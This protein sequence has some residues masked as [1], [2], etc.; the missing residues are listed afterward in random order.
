MKKEY[1]ISI[2]IFAGLVICF[3]GYDNYQKSQKLEIKNSEVSTNVKEISPIK[4]VEPQKEIE[5]KKY[6]TKTKS[7][8]FKSEKYVKDSIERF[9]TFYRDNWSDYI[10]ATKNQYQFREVGGIYDLSILFVNHTEYI[11]D[12]ITAR[13]NYLNPSGEIINSKEVTC[14]GLVPDG[15]R[16]VSIS[17]YN[18][19]VSVKVE[20]MDAKSKALNFWYSEKIEG[21]QDYD[22]WYWN[23]K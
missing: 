23:F 14:V 12:N 20:I 4:D 5:I 11:M 22:P 9:K 17:D 15:K 21:H 18:R 10:T 19:G 16:S 3:L 6:T 1:L 13:V 2:A 7:S 8:S